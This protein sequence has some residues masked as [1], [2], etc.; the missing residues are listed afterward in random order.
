MGGFCAHEVAA[1]NS[2]A[3]TR[4]VV[5]SR[6]FEL[7]I[8]SSSST[9]VLRFQL[10]PKSADL[11]VIAGP[12]LKTRGDDIGTVTAINT[13]QRRFHELLR[14]SDYQ[15]SNGRTIGLWYRRTFSNTCPGYEA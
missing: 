10:G 1:T 4:R 2:I 11:A 8:G 7:V 9:L 6:R 12:M 14:P 3:I 5:L 15:M 13:R